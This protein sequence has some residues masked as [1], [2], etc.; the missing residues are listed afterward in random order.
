[1]SNLVKSETQALSLFNPD[2]FQQLLQVAE[3][4]SKSDLVPKQYQALPGSEQKAIANTVIAFDMAQRM[5]ANPLMVMQNMHV[6][7]GRPSWSA[8]FIIAAINSSGRWDELEFDYIEAGQIKDIPYKEKVWD[9]KANQGR[10]AYVQQ[11]ATLKG[12]MQNLTCVCKTRKV[13]STKELVGPEVTMEMAIREGWYTKSDSKWQT[14]P[15]IMLMYRAATFWKSVYAPDIMMGMPSTEELRDIQ[16]TTFEDMTLAD[17][18]KAAAAPRET[19][20]IEKEP[21][22]ETK[23]EKSPEGVDP[24]TGEVK[25]TE[26]EK[27]K[28]EAA[29]KKA[30]KEAETAAKKAEEEA[31][32]Q[33]ELDAQAATQS[34]PD[35]VSALNDDLDE[36]SDFPSLAYN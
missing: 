14:M 27:K 36:E 23:E 2:Q 15:K 30:A 20:V 4:F 16:E 17:K 26:A 22:P 13:G 29:E 25:E 5:N 33:K 7:Q 12:P 32:K 31:F 28:R 24:E 21:E 34:D 8:Q 9:A 19:I 6:I 10:G 11:A 1:M 35:P 3:Y 18:V